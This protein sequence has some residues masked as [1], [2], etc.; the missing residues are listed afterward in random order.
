MPRRGDNISKRTVTRHRKDGTAYQVE[1]WTTLVDVGRDPLTG[2]RRRERIDGDSYGE[3]DKARQERLRQ[4]AGGLQV[5]TK[6]TQEW[7]VG[8]WCL[9][10]VETIIKTSGLSEG[11]YYSYLGD[12]RKNII[13]SP[14]GRKLLTKLQPSDVNQ[15]KVWLQAERKLAPSTRNRCL[16]VLRKALSEAK[17]QKLVVDNVAG[18]D[19]VDGVHVPKREPVA[20][21]QRQVQ[22]LLAQARQ[23][24]DR[25]LPMFALAFS[26]GMRQ[27]ELL[28]LKWASSETEPGLDLDRRVIRVRQQTVRYSGPTKI[29]N[30]VKR[31]SIRNPYMDAE[32]VEILRQHRV[33]QLK[34]QLKA[35]AKWKE[36]GLVFPTRIGT[37]QRNTNAWK[38]WKRLLKRSGLPTTFRFHD[39]RST[40]ASL[41]I[42][43]GAS[44]FD[45]S[46]ML[47]HSDIRTTANQYGHMFPE[48]QQEMAKR[49]GRLVLGELPPAA[50]SE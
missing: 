25:N 1:V 21:S 44:L 26:T 43:D 14:I 23:D 50:S 20:L 7:R 36:N 13:V 27:G 47:G 5:A 2:K 15:W 28:G 6:A 12:V 34:D 49:M 45:V 31:G 40:A 37:V 18:R 48:G 46:R 24:G 38:N 11:T 35:G 42:A 19:W 17:R 8:T 4:R 29:V 22:Q 32:L 39:Q 10:W 30:R 16:T 33:E 9:H 3:L 41:A